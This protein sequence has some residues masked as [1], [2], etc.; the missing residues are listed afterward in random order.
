MRE[1]DVL[2]SKALTAAVLT[3]VLSVFLLGGLMAVIVMTAGVHLLLE[4]WQ[5]RRRAALLRQP[6]DR[7]EK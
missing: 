3:A 7:T 4:D 5:T 1:K 2:L 6:R